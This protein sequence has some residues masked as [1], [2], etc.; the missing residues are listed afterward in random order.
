MAPSCV[1]AERLP[2][3]LYSPHAVAAQETG[4]ELKAMR[5]ARR[6]QSTLA[7]IDQVR[8]WLGSVEF[9]VGTCEPRWSVTA[10]RPR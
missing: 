9:V 10:I 6:G 7:R 4:S 3:Q 2:D 1:R 5:V 8:H